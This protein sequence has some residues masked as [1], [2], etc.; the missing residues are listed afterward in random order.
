V[1]ARTQSIDRDWGRHGYFT[2]GDASD[3]VVWLN[4]LNQHPDLTFTDP[5]V[6]AAVRS[7][8]SD[9]LASVVFQVRGVGVSDPVPRPPSI[10]EQVADLEAVLDHAGVR[11]ATLVGWLGTAL[12]AAVFAARHPDRV[13]GLV[14][15]SPTMTGPLAAPDEFGWTPER[16]RVCVDSWRGAAA[17]WG[18]GQSIAMWDPGAASPFNLRLFGM[19]ERCSVS[20]PYAAALIDAELELDGRDVY[21]QVRV[22]TRVLRPAGQVTFPAEVVRPVA[23][24]IPGA[25]YH[26][27]PLT[28]PGDSIGTQLEPVARHVAELARGAAA[29]TGT[30]E[31]VLAS[32]LFVDIV[33]STEELA[34]RG[35]AE[36]GKVLIGF[37]R[38]IRRATT[39][40][41]GRYVK[42]T[43]DGALCEF[44]G[45]GAAIRCAQRIAAGTPELGVAVRAGVHTGECEHLVGEDLAGIAVHIAAR[46]CAAAAPGEV[47]VTRAVRDLTAGSELR[48]APRGEC[49]LKGVPGSWELFA[50]GQEETP[51]GVLP[52]A[53]PRPLD[54][55]FL[56]MARRAPGAVRTASRMANAVQRRRVSAARRGP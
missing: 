29:R 16:V 37:E 22:P 2:I 33:G 19:V 9:R 21:P 54:R 5:V 44:S 43:G 46:V 41:D 28:H 38:L 42:S 23:E 34:R 24:A 15:I 45:P 55:A 39:A 25:E 36:W 4:E 56:G 17:Q 52:G 3:H 13:V 18:S 8:A 53:A 30:S 11:R 10:E 32:V 27:L 1:D 14:L 12:T 20:Q 49:E 31:R 51:A 48:F 6:A 35:D 47:T 7:L 40:E 26:E 50:A